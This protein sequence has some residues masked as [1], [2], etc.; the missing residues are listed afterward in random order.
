MAGV[1][2]VGYSV[3]CPDAVGITVHGTEHLGGTQKTAP[4]LDAGFRLE[5]QGVAGSAEEDIPNGYTN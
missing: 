3:Q 5:N 1:A 2:S 4:L